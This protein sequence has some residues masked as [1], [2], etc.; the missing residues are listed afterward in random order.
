MD[1]SLPVGNRCRRYLHGRNPH[2]R[3]DGGDTHLEGPLH[4]RRSFGG[5]PRGSRAHPARSGPSRRRTWATSCTAPRWPP[6]P[7][8]RGSWRR[9]A[10][11]PPKGSGTCWRIQRQIR[12]SLYDLL[13]EKPRPLAPRYLCFG[14][15]ER[16]D[17]CRNGGHSARRA[18]GRGRGRGAEGGGRGSARGV[19]PPRIPQP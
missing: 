2:R 4:P 11:S 15:P 6:T 10:S 3:G 12:P 5:L 13:F 16:L 1:T 8:S 19:L 14:I 17:A 9:P 7:S 18:G